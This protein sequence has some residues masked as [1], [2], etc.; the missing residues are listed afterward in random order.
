MD[1]ITIHQIDFVSHE[2]HETIPIAAF[3]ANDVPAF[4]CGHGALPDDALHSFDSQGVVYE[5][6]FLRTI[7]LMAWGASPDQRASHCTPDVRPG[8]RVQ[9]AHLAA[10]ETGRRV[11]SKD[12]D[13]ER[14]A[15]GD[16]SWRSRHRGYGDG[17]CEWVQ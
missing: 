14:I 8:M 6:Q 4:C 5:W 13:N 17:G 7:L 15:L 16:F 9:R 2:L 11:S 1:Q 3:S 10:R 12:R